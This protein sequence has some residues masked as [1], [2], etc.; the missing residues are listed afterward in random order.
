MSEPL[1][2]L[3][4]LDQLLAEAALRVAKVVK[5]AKE[6]TELTPTLH[7]RISSLP[8]VPYFSRRAVPRADNFGQVTTC[9]HLPPHASTCLHLP[10]PA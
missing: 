4:R 5:E 9:L 10:P 6:A 2:F 7:L 8:A 3:P 1:T